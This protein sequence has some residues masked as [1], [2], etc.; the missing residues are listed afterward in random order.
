MTKYIIVLTSACFLAL[1]LAS[2]PSAA[3]TQ[4]K[5]PHVEGK[6]FIGTVVI[7]DNIKKTLVVK[8]WWRELTFD[9]A[10]ARF[11]DNESLKDIEPGEKVLIRYV[12]EGGS[13][14]AKSVVRATTK[15]ENDRKTGSPAQTENQVGTPE[16]H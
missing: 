11:A 3:T 14:V 4:S 7:A 1:A 9:V 15:Y 16:S 8:A 13:K 5:R 2:S 12:V 6:R 10:T